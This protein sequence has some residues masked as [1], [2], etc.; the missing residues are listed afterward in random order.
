MDR[1]QNVYTVVEH[2]KYNRR[3]AGW[4]VSSLAG[5][6]RTTGDVLTRTNKKVT[7][8]IHS[9]KKTYTT[10]LLQTQERLDTLPEWKS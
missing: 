4:R 7:Y 9:D 2:E 6:L 10:P 3:E 1:R 8:F 5:L